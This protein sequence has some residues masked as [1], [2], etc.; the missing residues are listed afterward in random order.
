MNRGPEHGQY[1]APGNS[2]K[3]PGMRVANIKKARREALFRLTACFR[4]R[5]GPGK[6]R[7]GKAPEKTLFHPRML[8]PDRPGNQVGPSRA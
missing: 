3:R 7:A 6:D 1:G 4:Q 5:P 8:D 2:P